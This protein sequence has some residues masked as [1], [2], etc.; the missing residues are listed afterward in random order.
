ATDPSPRLSDRPPA[1]RNVGTL[2]SAGRRSGEPPAPLL[3]RAPSEPDRRAARAA[4]SALR[5]SERGARARAEEEPRLLEA[6]FGAGR[7]S[8]GVRRA[9]R[10]LAEQRH[11][12][13]RAAH[14]P[15]RR[16]VPGAGPAPAICLLPRP[17]QNDRLATAGG[18]V[19]PQIAVPFVGAR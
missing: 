6:P 17:A 5:R 13:D 14:G 10:P 7:R 11:D 2:Q 18:A 15:L 1:D 12:G 4:R 8:G 19:A 16:V 9:P 3:G